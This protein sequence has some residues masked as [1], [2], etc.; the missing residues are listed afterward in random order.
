MVEWNRAVEAPFPRAAVDGAACGG[1]E[2]AARYLCDTSRMRRGA[3][4][5]IRYGILE[6]A[7]VWRICGAAG[8]GL[9]GG[10][11]RG[12]GWGAGRQEGGGQEGRVLSASPVAV[13]SGTYG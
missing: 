11:V 7:C 3:L 6:G 13:H 8:G 5:A 12:G 4:S 9:G 10:G 2:W 1:A